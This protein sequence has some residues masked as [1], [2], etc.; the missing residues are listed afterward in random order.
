MAEKLVALISGASAGIGA[1]S[2]RA[3]AREGYGLLLGA[4]RMDRLEQ[5]AAGIRAE[6]GVPVWCGTL[7]VRDGRSVAAFV[8]DGVAALGGGWAA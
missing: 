1:A 3:L 2:A 4:R 7:D 8:D 5:L 6:F